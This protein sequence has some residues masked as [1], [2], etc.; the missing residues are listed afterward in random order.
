MKAFINKTSHPQ[1]ERGS[2]LILAMF[3]SIVTVGITVSGTYMMKAHRTRTEATFV[4]S[5]QAGQFGR[6][7]ITE[8]LNWFRLQSSQPVQVFNPVFDGVADPQILETDEPEIGLVRS[9]Q[10]N[11]IFWGRYEVWKQ[12]DADPDP[13]RLA[14]RQRMQ[15]KDVSALRGDPQ[16]GSVWRVRCIGYVYRNVDPNRAFD[17]S[18]NQVLG[19]EILETELR[20]LNL[21]PPAAA[22]M[23]IS[24]GANATITGDGYVD[25]GSNG[26]GVG[27]SNAKGTKAPKNEKGKAKGTYKIEGTPASSPIPDYD[28][29]VAS[30]FGVQ[31][32]ELPLRQSQNPQK[33]IPG[34]LRFS[35]DDGDLLLEEP[36]E[37]R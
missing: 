17:E 20:R 21:S 7:G 31:E 10:I 33:P 6:S 14:W 16:P 30:V 28:A 3:V 11:G 25:G 15:A 9:F 29:S 4:M 13:E 26:A 8:A 5:G 32:Q 36:I 23:S 18:P 34:G 1:G 22:A 24:D 2:D 12:W 37:Q 19:R 27:Y 35:R